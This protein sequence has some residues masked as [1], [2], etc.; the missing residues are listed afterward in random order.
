[1]VAWED[2]V[3]SL[4]TNGKPGAY[5]ARIGSDRE[6]FVRICSTYVANGA[7]LDDGVLVRDAWKLAR[8]PAR[9]FHGRFDLGSP[10]HIAYE[11]HDAWVGSELIVIDDSGHTGSKSMTARLRREIDAFAEL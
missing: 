5:S 3:I 6:A 11:L 7:W 1:M 9:L 4:E 2:A 8:I 10:V